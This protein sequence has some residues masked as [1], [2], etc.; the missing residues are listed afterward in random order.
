MG[1]DK[2][3]TI[4]QLMKNLQ[5]SRRL[6]EENQKIQVINKENLLVDDQEKKQKVSENQNIKL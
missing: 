1:D 3:K 2:G 5:F 4:D 6:V